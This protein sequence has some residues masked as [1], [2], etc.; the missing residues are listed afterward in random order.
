M[1]VAS[2]TTDQ[3]LQAYRDTLGRTPGPE[4]VDFWVNYSTTNDPTQTA[5]AFLAGAQD[6]L[7]SRQAINIP[8]ATSSDLVLNPPTRTTIPAP[9]D[10]SSLA[11]TGPVRP[12]PQPSVTSDQIVESYTKYLNRTPSADE[13]SFWTNY[14]TTNDPTQ[15]ANAFLAGAKNE[16]ANVTKSGYESYL[17]RTPNQEELNFWTNYTVEQ[18]APQAAAAW[19][20]GADQE[21]AARNVPSSV[22]E[23]QILDSYNKFFN[24]TPSADEVSFW[25]NYGRTADPTQTANAFINSA[26]KEIGDITK[27]GY[28]SYLGREPTQDEL[29]FWTNYTIEND[30][31]QA[32]NAWKAGADE[33]LSRRKAAVDVDTTLQNSNLTGSLVSESTAG[34]P[35]AGGIYKRTPQEEVMYLKELSRIPVN[36]AVPLPVMPM[37]LGPSDA[38]TRARQPGDIGEGAYYAAIRDVVTSGDYTPAQLRQMQ[39]NVGTSGQDINVAFGRGMTPITTTT[40]TMPGATT[41]TTQSI[42]QFI[43]SKAPTT[44]VAMP[45]APSMFSPENVRA[46]LE[47]ERLRL[48]PTPEPPPEEPVAGFAQGGLVNDDIN[49]MLQN[50]RNAI[51]RES[52]SRQMLTNL[53]APPVKK[54]SDGGPAGSSSSGVRRLKMSGYQEGGE[55]TDEMFVGTLPTDQGTN[56]GILPPEIR[57]P[58]DVGLDLANTALRGTAA[59][60]AGPVYG[61]YKGVTGGQYGTPEGV[62]V[63]EQAATN[64][65]STIT[66]EP[67]TQG[68]RDIMDFVG[69]K[70]EEAKIPMMPQFLT[71]PL[72]APG[73]ARAAMRALDMDKPPTGAVTLA[74]P[75]TPSLDSLGMSSRLSEA[76][77]RLQARGTGEQ[78][79]AQLNKAQGV[80]QAEIKATG[81]DEFLKSAGKVTRDDIQGYLEKNRVN[82]VEDERSFAGAPIDDLSKKTMGKEFPYLRGDFFN[83]R[84]ANLDQVKEAGYNALKA[85]RD[86]LQEQFTYGDLNLFRDRDGF[87]VLPD[88]LDDWFRREND[89]LEQYIDD[90]ALED[91]R[92]KHNQLTLPGGDNYR[93]VLFKL[94]KK[95]GQQAF[96]PPASHYEDAANTFGSIR[97]T[98]RV[99]DGKPI[100][101]AEEVQSDW[102]IKGAK[103]GYDEPEK[104][105]RRNQQLSEAR[106]ALAQAE[107]RAEAAKKAF[108]NRGPQDESLQLLGNMEFAQQ[109]AEKVRRFIQALEIKATPENPFKNNWY[110][111]VMNRFLIKAAQEGK[112]GIGLTNGEVHIQRYNLRNYTDKVIYNP[113]TKLFA[114]FDRATDDVAKNIYQNIDEPK[115]RRMIGD[116]TA[117]KL[118][119]SGSKTD[120]AMGDDIFVLSGNQ[121]EI[122]GSGKNT[123]Y[124]KILPDYLNKLGKKYGVKVETRKLP[125]FSDQ[126]KSTVNPLGRISDEK[127]REIYYL[128]LTEE[129]RNDLLGKGLPTFKKGGEVTNDE[130][131]QQVM[132]G[133][134]MSDTSTRPG[135]LP[136]ELREAIDVPLDFANLLIRGTAAVPIGGFAGLYKGLTGGKYGTQE[137]VKEADTEAARMMAEITGEPKT[138]TAKDVLQFVGDKMQEYKLDAPM[139]QLL[140]LPS[141]GA[142]TTEFIKQAVRSEF[143]APPVGAVD[144]GALMPKPKKGVELSEQEVGKLVD[145]SQVS[146]EQ[147]PALVE[148]ARRVKEIFNT[149]QGWEPMELI[150]AKIKPGKEDN[151][152][153]DLEAQK[154]PYNFHIV[155][156]GM[157]KPAWEKKIS[158]GIVGEVRKVVERA[159]AGDQKALDILSQASWYRSMRKRLR[160]EFGS[161]GDVFADVLGTTSAQTGVEQNFNNAIEILRRYSRGEYDKELKAYEDRLKSG[162]SMDGTELTQLHKKGE[163]PLITKASGALFNANSPSSMGALLDMFRSVRTGDSPKTPNF[164][165]NLIGLTNEATVDVWA[166]RLLRRL[167]GKK[168][169]PPMAEKGVSGKHLVGS[170]LYEPKV[171]GEF[172]FGQKVFKDAA[173]RINK[174]GVIK[175]FDPKIGDVGPDDLQ[176]IAWFIEKERWTD[177]GW[178]S[179]AGE[180]GSLEYEMSFA[181]APNQAMVNDLRREINKGFKE[182][183]QRKKES[184][185]DHALRVEAARQAY[186]GNRQ[187]L[188]N[189]LSLLKK[190]VD[191]YQIGL[192]GERPGKPLASGYQRA[193]LAAGVDDVVRDDQNVI[194]YN[195]TNSYGSFMS[196]VERALNGE[197]VV[198]GNF[199]PIPLE[200]RVVELGKEY[201]QD[202][203]FLSKVLPDGQSANARPGIEIYFKEKV[204]PEQMA[205][206]TERLRNYGVDGFTYVTD[207]R[208]SDRPGMQVRAGSPETAELT[209]LRF[210][211]VPE[212]DDAYSPETRGAIIKGKERLYREILRGIITDGNVSDARMLYYDT[213]VFLKGGYDEYLARTTPGGSGRVRPG[214]PDSSDTARSAQGAAVGAELSGDVRDGRDQASSAPAAEGV[215]RRRGKGTTS[216]AEDLAAIS[217]TAPAVSRVDMGYKDVTKRVPEL[218]KGANDLLEGKITWEDYNALVDQYKPVTPYSFVPQPATGADAM[219]ALDSRKQKSFAVIQ[220]GIKAGETAELRLDIPAYKDHGVWVNSIHRSGQPTSYASI[221]S[222]KNARMIG[223]DDVRLQ[224]KALE[225]AT[226]QKTKGPFAVIKGEWSPVSE[227]EAV[228]RAQQY[229]NDPE[230]TQVGYDPERHSY[231]YDRTTTQPVVSADE[232]LQIGPLVLAKNA[233]FAKK[234]QFKFKSGGEV[235]AFIK[236]K[237]K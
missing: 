157:A 148:T 52:Q 101:F 196:E 174:T 229:L 164:T 5:N 149:N 127:A 150:R 104:A 64:L 217:P 45:T 70:V 198:R 14:S 108:Q 177:N 90:I 162:E 11:A 144:I 169:I 75:P 15:T 219:K 36:A 107:A 179:K 132:T 181:G 96:I 23:Q 26:R 2:V 205:K 122:G 25:V 201:D 100:L 233:K 67:K 182:P 151:L 62:R 43:Q 22:T 235:N 12:V 4:E 46:Q 133:T 20:A 143:E 190:D 72:P 17:G 153:V 159:K 74:A 165:G 220:E 115:L 121:L 106:Q 131:I 172:G 195:L 129:M 48:Q 146:D 32:A 68:A 204:S 210:Q 78:L 21:L 3:I 234:E 189:Q 236:A 76:V 156:E 1:A 63:G 30:A 223:P 33:E 113:K 191:R 228:A 218:T 171:G 61:L 73:S 168:R 221:S 184:D 50:Q 215:K 200:R 183:P 6:E 79:L 226:G 199:D 84:Y 82:L 166:A 88:E 7:A 128:P 130:F 222:I 89:Y 34:I 176:A 202:A 42:D 69:Q 94:P 136:P 35:Y 111:P 193:E 38:L 194:A 92:V 175:N 186:D 142:G 28:E 192:S 54:F 163:F 71:M 120:S 197:F 81:L 13:V 59:A 99:V 124:D 207:M 178:T 116:E 39:R 126:Q 37:S 141:P 65:M 97:M 98:D 102:A 105:A 44:S 55:V 9:V 139:P 103:E 180:G 83:R 91:S 29:D 16:I 154:I 51:Q 60:V 227:K 77:D 31:V 125:A 24:R 93:E 8:A 173:N 114:V 161:I 135:I 86:E 231:F 188:I 152:A 209:G 66:G 134:P 87:E 18:G 211:Y 208:F 185:Q 27:S 19:K 213:K 155:P 118:L 41:G 203:V 158:N 206:V 140:T 225:V 119:N 160:T 109:N 147:A 170:T 53:G 187:N 224:E 10:V 117:E 145:S 237:A 58:I 232:V 138:Q 167:S 214:Q 40:P 80:P 110:Q 230:W 57:K 47:L 56:P 85:E 216:A 112:E 123:F 95:E 49:R 137:G 212:F